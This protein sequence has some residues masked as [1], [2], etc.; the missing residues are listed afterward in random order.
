MIVMPKR[1][2]PLTEMQV[3][4]AKTR[5]KEYKLSDG[6]GLHLLVTPSGGK[7]WRLQYLFAGKQKSV[8]F[9]A[10]PAVP[11]SEARRRRDESREQIGNG[12]DP[13]AVKK[14]QKSA[15]VSAAENSFEVVAREW[16]A[17]FEETWTDG[18]AGTIVSRLERDVFPWVGAVP[19]A[20]LEAPE[21]LAVL[22]RVQARGALE[23]AHRVKGIFGQV[24]RYAIAT[25]R[26]RRDVS[27]DLKGALPQPI[28][29]SHAAITDPQEVVQLL[30]ASDSYRGT[31]VVRCALRLAPLVFLRPGELR[32]AEWC[33]FD[34]AKAEWNVPIERLKLTKMEK[35]KRKG[36][37]HLVPLSRQAVE[38]LKELQ[39]LTG[40]SRYVF[41][42]GRSYDRCMSENAV[43]AALRR[44]GFDKET[45][46]GHGF[47]AMARTILDEI[48]KFRPDIIEHQLA[49][50]VKDPNGRA[51]NRT[52]HIEDRQEMMQRWADYLDELKNGK[53]PLSVLH[54]GTGE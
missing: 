26:A 34:L 45:M 5:D 27:A 16:F 50:T 51:Y 47:R 33:E 25:G 28:A 11:L 42:G 18:H 37:A 54:S 12:I 49:H 38:I 44:M 9:G 20:E 41:T 3:K 39:P 10:Y 17:Q 2:Q 14:A 40:R 53:A 43:L 30:K 29:Q 1:I 48:L 24:F 8:A 46:T 31:L 23:S 19:I 35:A 52:T 4:N 36:D 13:G 6:L 15:K 32:H 7:L 21:V 22:R